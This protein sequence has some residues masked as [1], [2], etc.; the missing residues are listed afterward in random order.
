MI[1][2]PG[3]VIRSA[4]FSYFSFVPATLYQAF[5]RTVRFWKLKVGFPLLSNAYSKASALT[6]GHGWE[7]QKLSI[8]PAGPVAL[9]RASAACPFFVPELEESESD[10]SMNSVD[11]CAVAVPDF[12][13]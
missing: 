6:D 10:P 1:V 13:I 11:A 4:P 3:F 5:E 7:Y 12:L 2:T 9:T 8:Q